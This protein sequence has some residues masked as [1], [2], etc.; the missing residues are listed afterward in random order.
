M[1]K[2][3]GKCNKK[4]LD[5]AKKSAIDAIKNAWKNGI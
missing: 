3:C 5:H 2:N 1:W 4:I